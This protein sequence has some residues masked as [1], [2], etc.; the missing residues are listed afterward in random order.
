MINSQ[1]NLA[2]MW[3]PRK[4]YGP[5]TTEIA[6]DIW[7]SPSAARRSSSSAI[8]PAS[9]Q[10]MPR[11]AAEIGH[12]ARLFGPGVPHHARPGADF[13]DDDLAAPPAIFEDAPRRRIEI[14]PVGLR[15]DGDERGS[16]RLAPSC[17]G[18]VDIGGAG[19]PG[20]CDGRDIGHR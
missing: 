5:A 10:T 4:C 20:D 2:S 1:S 14:D 19:E 6:T 15:P 8:F 13:F 9:T 12:A 11:Q 3:T 17:F 7:C 16:L 18:L